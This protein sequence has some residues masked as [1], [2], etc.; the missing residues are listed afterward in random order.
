MSLTKIK[1]IKIFTIQ[2]IEKKII[3]LKIEILELKIKKATR[4]SVKN[5]ILKQKKT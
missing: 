1:D 5:H 4:Q 3:D 2:E